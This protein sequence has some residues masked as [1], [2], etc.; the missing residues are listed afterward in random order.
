MSFFTSPNFPRIAPGLWRTFLRN[1]V[2]WTRIRVSKKRFRTCRS[3]PYFRPPAREMDQSSIGVKSHCCERRS[4]KGIRLSGWPL[5]CWPLSF[6]VFGEGAP[7]R[8]ARQDPFGELPQ[9]PGYSKTSIMRTK[10]GSRFVTVPRGVVERERFT[11]VRAESLGPEGE[12]ALMTFKSMN[13]ALR[14]REV[15][16]PAPKGPGWRTEWPRKS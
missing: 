15:I 8:T 2:V 5:L 6:W 12:R 7:V 13:P 16:F 10:A 1:P 3:L 11:P 14:L 4:L 9:S